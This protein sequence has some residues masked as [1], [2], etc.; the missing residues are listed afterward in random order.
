VDSLGANGKIGRSRKL[1]S[2]SAKVRLEAGVRLEFQGRG[3]E[4]I[5]ESENSLG[6]R[7]ISCKSTTPCT[8][9]TSQAPDLPQTIN[10]N[11][12]NSVSGRFPFG[13]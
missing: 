10:T 4:F 12:A 3:L 13:D 11:K 6:E 8:L 9:P 1:V 5:S 7:E 2:G